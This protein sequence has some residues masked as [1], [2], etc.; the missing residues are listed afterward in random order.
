MN[1]KKNV[2][3]NN[4]IIILGFQNQIKRTTFVLHSIETVVMKNLKL[5][6][7]NLSRK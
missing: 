1:S 4:L 6:Q 7:K 2:N 5:L 3:V